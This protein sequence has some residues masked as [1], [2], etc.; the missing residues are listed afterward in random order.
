MLHL[1]AHQ[2]AKHREGYVFMPFGNQGNLPRVVA[3]LAQFYALELWKNEE[4]EKHFHETLLTVPSSNTLNV[5]K[6]AGF[7]ATV[8]IGGSLE[9]VYVKELA[10]HSDLQHLGTILLAETH[11]GGHKTT[12]FA[13]SQFE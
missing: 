4:L 12:Q 6:G 3:S 1:A 11:E 13:R 2:Y 8:D 5:L 10:A 9:D 7:E